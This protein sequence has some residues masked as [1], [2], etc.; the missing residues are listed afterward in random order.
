MRKTWFRL[1]TGP[2]AGLTIPALLFTD[3][4]HFFVTHENG[5]FYG[6][7]TADATEVHRRAT[8]I[9]IPERYGPNLAVEYVI[10][11]GG[12]E[13]L[14][15]CPANMLL[16]RGC[17]MQPVLD[18][19]AAHSLK[20]YDTWGNKLM[21]RAIKAILFG[22][23]DYRMTAA[24]AAAFFENDQNFVLATPTIAPSPAAEQP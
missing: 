14:R 22:K 6:P 3:P 17:F 24:R 15:L 8:A 4:G 16:E 21:L 23:S 10:D 18:M 12:F 5:E 11:R 1:T 20:P 2:H 7:I 19:S 9:R 13:D